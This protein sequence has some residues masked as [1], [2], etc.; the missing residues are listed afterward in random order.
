MI[1]IKLSIKIISAEVQKNKKEGSK[2]I[3]TQVL[4]PIVLILQI[5]F[6]KYQSSIIKIWFIIIKIKILTKTTGHLYN[7]NILINRERLIIIQTK[8]SQV[9]LINFDKLFHLMTVYWI[10]TKISFI[11]IIILNLNL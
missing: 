5:I 8:V 2:N 1:K 10:Q 11:K 9:S 3:L 7:Q 4:T 6:K